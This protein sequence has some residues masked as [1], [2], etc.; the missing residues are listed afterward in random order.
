MSRPDPSEAE[1]P[2]PTVLVAAD[3]SADT[4][5]ARRSL[6][7]LGARVLVAA[8]PAEAVTTLE[9]D[10]DGGT[11]TGIRLV[12]IALSQNGQELLAMIKGNPAL[13]WVPVVLITPEEAQEE[14][15]RTYDLQANAHVVRPDPLSDEPDLFRAIS[16]FWLHAV[17]VSHD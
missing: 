4:E 9:E 2:R 14:V 10:A 7:D 17:V 16:D 12:L 3:E 13:R 6:E 11:G 15:E 5:A 1:Q 8:S